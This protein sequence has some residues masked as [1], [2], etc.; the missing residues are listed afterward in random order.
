MVAIRLSR[1][2]KKGHASF[3]FVVSDKRKDMYGPALE[4]LGWYDPHMKPTKIEVKADRILY[5]L[6]KGA[7]SS[8][9]VHNLLVGAGV[10]KGEKVVKAHAKKAKVEP[11]AP[12]KKE[13]VKGEA[14][15]EEKKV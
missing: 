13:A 1:V 5:W 9:T 10:I 4:I 7:Q 2:G 15:V 11:V 12:V 14:K 3:R 8:A 6:S